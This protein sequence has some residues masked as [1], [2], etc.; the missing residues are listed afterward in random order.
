MGYGLWLLFIYSLSVNAEIYKWIDGNG[1]THFTDRPPSDV[2]TETITPKINSYSAVSVTP[3]ITR[4]GHDDKVVIYSAEWCGYCNKAKKY[5]RK[6]KI[7]YVAY[8]VEKSRRGR[9][10]YKLLKGRSVPIIIVGKKRMNG[11]NIA[12]FEKLYRET[13]E[14]RQAELP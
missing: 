4:L 14:E 12:R 3:L 6:N 2:K 9:M 7:P 5:F 10:D 8:D 11:F 13:Q 1:K